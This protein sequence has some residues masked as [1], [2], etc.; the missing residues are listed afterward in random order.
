MEHYLTVNEEAIEIPAEND[1]LV[2]RF[3]KVGRHPK[4]A[5]HA[6]RVVEESHST[7]TR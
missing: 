4:R 7:S 5:V 3:G 2:K 1:G 6:E